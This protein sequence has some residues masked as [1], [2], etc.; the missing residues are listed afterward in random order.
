MSAALSELEQAAGILLGPP[1]LVNPEQRSAAES[2]FLQFRKTKCPYSM[3]KVIYVAV[4]LNM[5][6]FGSS[7]E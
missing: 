6:P 2:L 4:C 7:K 1:N 3:C 5:K